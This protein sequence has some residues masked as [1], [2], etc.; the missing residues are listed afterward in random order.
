VGGHVKEA[1]IHPTLELWLRT[2]DIPVR[3]TKDPETAPDLP[4]LLDLPEWGGQR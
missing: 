2:E 1:R 4:D 3:R